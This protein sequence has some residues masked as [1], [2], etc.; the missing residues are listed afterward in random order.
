MRDAAEIERRL[1]DFKEGSGIAVRVLVTPSLHGRT[2]DDVADEVLGAWHLAP[3]DIFLLVAP[4]EHMSWI[5]PG[6]SVRLQVLDAREIIEQRIDPL[7]RVGQTRAAVLEG[8]EA[9][10]A[11]LA[12]SW[13]RPFSFSFV[14]PTLQRFGTRTQ[15]VALVFFVALV[16]VTWLFRRQ[17]KS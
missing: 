14:S 16:G 4:V 3:T 17:R 2:I 13:S 5:Q 10:Q 12:P 15:W 11:L 9:L 8:T 6:D 1:R 7:L